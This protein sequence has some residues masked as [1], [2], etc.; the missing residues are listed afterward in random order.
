[1]S[2]EPKLMAEARCGPSICRAVLAAGEGVL[3]SSEH[4][5]QAGFNALLLRLAEVAAFTK[6]N[7]FEVGEGSKLAEGPAALLQMQQHTLMNLFC[8][9]APPMQVMSD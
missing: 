9:H 1:M 5:C 7:C 4:I 8:K 3:A 2:T 6:L